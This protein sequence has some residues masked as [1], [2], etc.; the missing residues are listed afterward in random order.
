MYMGIYTVVP[1]FME[2]TMHVCF[3][4][5]HGDDDHSMPRASKTTKTV[6]M[7]PTRIAVYELQQHMSH[8][9]CGHGFL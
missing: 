6:G 8:V 9:I 4:D 2:I 5:R 1:S 3:K 7:P